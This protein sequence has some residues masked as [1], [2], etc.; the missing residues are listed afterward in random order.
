M[1]LVWKSKGRPSTCLVVTAWNHGRHD[2]PEVFIQQ[3]RGVASWLD[4][5]NSSFVDMFRPRLNMRHAGVARG[6]I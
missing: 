2:K 3:P 4:L 6:T 1:Q 5:V